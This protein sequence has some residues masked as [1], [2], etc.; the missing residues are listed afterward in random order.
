MAAIHEKASG[1]SDITHVLAC[2]TLLL[3]AV[4]LAVGSMYV[5]CW[6]HSRLS[7]YYI[8]T[9]YQNTINVRNRLKIAKTYL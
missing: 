2:R 4:T 6:L 1:R 3:L 5:V 9:I 7:V 8:L